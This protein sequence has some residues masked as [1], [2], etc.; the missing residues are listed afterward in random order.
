LDLFNQILRFEEQNNALQMPAT[1]VDT[2]HQTGPQVEEADPEITAE[3][4]EVG[5]K[6]LDE[7]TPASKLP[8]LVT[9]DQPVR[10]AGHQL[11]FKN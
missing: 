3:D 5:P 2:N 7:I 1:S 6:H 8:A 9:K 4:D 10:E 11:D